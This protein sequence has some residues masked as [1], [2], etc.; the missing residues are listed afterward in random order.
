MYFDDANYADWCWYGASRLPARIPGQAKWLEYAKAASPDVAW[1]VYVD[2]YDYA[3]AD[4]SA[5]QANTNKLTDLI[6]A[7]YIDPLDGDETAV[8]QELATAIKPKIQA[9][10]QTV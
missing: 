10:L 4:W 7:E 8:A 2:A 9:L 6:Q 5:T 3:S 1:S